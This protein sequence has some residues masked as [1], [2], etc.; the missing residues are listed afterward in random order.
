M[1][2]NIFKPGQ[3]EGEL[4]KSLE[5]LPDQI[6]TAKLKWQGSILK[7]EKEEA[8][9]C[10]EIRLKNPDITS[11]E[12]KELLYLS[13]KRQEIK[14]LEIV[15]EAEYERLYEMLMTKKILARLRTAF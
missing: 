2:G 7:R 6:Y 5:E 13:D 9:I 8:L 1:K 4:E 11:T 3:I 12:V 14:M 10:A 15:N